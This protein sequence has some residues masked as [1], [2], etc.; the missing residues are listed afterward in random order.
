MVLITD[1]TG[2]EDDDELED[3]AAA[4][5]DGGGGAELGTM[6]WM[7]LSMMAMPWPASM[8]LTEAR[9]RKTKSVNRERDSKGIIWKKK[10]R[11]KEYRDRKKLSQK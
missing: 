10:K 5:V 2:P 1:T 4:A 8:W 6:S 11:R 9:A 3:E 7:M